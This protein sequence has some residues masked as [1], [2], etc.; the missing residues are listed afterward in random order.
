MYGDLYEYLI[1]SKQL[2]VPGIGTFLL[3]RKP[4]GTDLTHRQINPPAYTISLYHNSGMPAKKFFYWL[5]DRLHIHYNEAIVRFNGF[6]Y[7]LKNQVMSGDKI[8]WDKVGVLSKGM[9]GDVRFE[10]ALKEYR[11]DAP[12][13]AAKIIR[14]KAVHNVR[15]GELEKTSAEMTEWLHPEEENKSYWWAP[16]LVVAIVLVIIAGIYF[17]QMGVSLSSAANQQKLSPQKGSVTH[18]MLQ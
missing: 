8:T 13:S 6:A 1:L 9:T 18:T 15:V 10:P 16:S 14:E 2:S 17:S 3:E 4:A 11:F 5:A 12:V 7:D